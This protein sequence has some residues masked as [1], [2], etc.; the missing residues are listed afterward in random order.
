MLLTSS[1]ALCQYH[2]D[3]IS[4]V[5]NTPG[6]VA[7]WDF[8]KREPG[9]ARRFTAHVPPGATNDYPL[10][11]GNYVK[12]YSGEGREATYDDFP[13]LG[14]GPFGQAVQIRKEQDPTFRPFLFVPRSRLH[15]SP[16]DIQGAK[17]SVSIVVWAIR[18]S[19]SHAMAGIWHEGT[20]LKQKQTEKIQKIEPGQRQY[21][22]FAGL[23]KEGTACGHVSENGGGSFGH[24]YAWNKCYSNGSSPLVPANSPP[25]VLDESWQCFAMTFDFGKQEL[26]GWLNGKSGDLWQED[27]KKNAAPIYTA[28][29][30]GKLGKSD[31]VSCVKDLAFPADQYFN[32]PE[33]TPVSVTIL[34]QTDQ[35]RVELQEFRYT[36][37]KV[38]LRK[39]GQGEFAVA[40]RD[41]AAVRLNPW[42]FPHAIYSPDSTQGG[43][44][45]IGRVIHSARDV[46]FTGWI[47]GVAVF[48]R[49]LSASEL[50][51]LSS[52]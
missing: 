37:V 41:L 32:P 12:D 16:L 14:C 48:D 5:T 38:T 44:F 31:G 6:L 10:D 34:S 30:Q 49:A 43:P 39:G 15:G 35:E 17:K 1:T 51:K 13:L 11:A 24:K 9:G 45:T 46:G 22:L 33:D 36:R 52:L 29:I 20:D 40:S 28:W 3:Q 23:G 27:V 19:G 18:E 47:G 7:F 25:E 42:W 26:T 8:V 50:E 2:S 4:A 21:A